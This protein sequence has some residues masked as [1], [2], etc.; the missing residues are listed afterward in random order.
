MLSGK[1]ISF[2]LKYLVFQMEQK[3]RSNCW[4]R[5]ILSKGS[6]MTHIPNLNTCLLS[7]NGIF[8]YLLEKPCGE[9]SLSQSMVWLTL[10]GTLKMSKGV[11]GSNSWISS[12][13]IEL[14]FWI[15][16]SLRLAM[17]GAS[18]PS[19]ITSVQKGIY[20]IFFVNIFFCR[21]L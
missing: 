1:F 18:S 14:V 10:F 12:I 3:S 21:Q 11:Y 13:E 4:M 19:K 5:N 7:N 20:K 2:P 17:K 15:F 16:L 6:R 9:N 8:F